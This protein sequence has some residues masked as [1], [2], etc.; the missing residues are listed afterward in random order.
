[1]ENKKSAISR[2]KRLLEKWL[3]KLA[4]PLP[5]PHGTCIGVCEFPEG[6]SMIRVDFYVDDIIND[7]SDTQPEKVVVLRKKKGAICACLGILHLSQATRTGANPSGLSRFATAPISRLKAPDKARVMFPSPRPVEA[8]LLSIYMPA[9]DQPLATV[10]RTAIVSLVQAVRSRK[11]DTLGTDEPILRAAQPILL[12]QGLRLVIEG[13]ICRIPHLATR[14]RACE[15]LRGVLLQVY[16]DRPVEERMRALGALGPASRDR[17]DGSIYVHAS[18][19][20]L[21][22][23]CVPELLGLVSEEERKSGILEIALVEGRPAMRV[24]QDRLETVYRAALLRRCRLIC[25][26][27]ATLASALEKTGVLPGPD[28][29]IGERALERERDAEGGPEPE[30]SLW[31][32]FSKLAYVDNSKPPPTPRHWYP[33][34]AR[35]ERPEFKP[36]LLAGLSDLF[37]S[38]SLSSPAPSQESTN[39]AVAT[40]KSR[41][42]YFAQ[43]GDIEELAS[44]QGPAPMCVRLATVKFLDTI[45][46]PKHEERMFLAN[47]FRAL[48][49]KRKAVVEVFRGVLENSESSRSSSYDIAKA[50][51]EVRNILGLF[52]NPQ[53]SDD[54]DDDTDEAPKREDF[55]NTCHTLISRD[56]LQTT[57][58]CP[59][60]SKDRAF[61]HNMLVSRGA[62]PEQD[63]ER[64]SQALSLRDRVTEETCRMACREQ[65]MYSGVQIENPQNLPY[66]P[67]L[68][69]ERVAG[70]HT[71]EPEIVLH[72]A[73]RRKR[74]APLEME[75]PTQKRTSPLPQS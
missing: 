75:G 29:S 34:G 5:L 45:S 24:A 26:I 62:V 20:L 4:Y 9:S 61:L 1:M 69:I 65:Q 56:P 16:A 50:L 11:W 44:P 14:A 53:D 73:S 55:S 17:R 3:R 47:L 37:S 41:K 25:R 52:S 60:V 32:V 30:N 35:P 72:R 31:S 49:M 46:H 7:D 57:A 54:D 2:Q 63:A 15:W 27:D 39:R 6:A 23:P 12:V 66:K 8:R 42:G 36:R 21:S 51:D 22:P 10:C 67:L 40:Q 43:G 59:F 28:D 71:G 33:M 19:L 38:C 64:L 70:V 18:T 13:V 74:S 48:G 58:A 68:E